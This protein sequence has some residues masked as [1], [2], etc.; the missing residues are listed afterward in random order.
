MIGM[1]VR[2]LGRDPVAGAS[3]GLCLAKVVVISTLPAGAIVGLVAGR[4]ATAGRGSGFP[5][6]V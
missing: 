5:L 4:R 6:S 2:I 1:L 3:V